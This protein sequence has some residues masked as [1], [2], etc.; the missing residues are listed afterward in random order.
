MPQ[1]APTSDAIAEQKLQ[2]AARHAD[3]TAQRPDVALRAAGGD[4]AAIEEA[5][6]LSADLVVQ[7]EGLD[8]AEREAQGWV[9]ATRSE[10]E[11]RDHQERLAEAERVHGVL[12]AEVAAADAVIGDRLLDALGRVMTMARAAD[13]ARISAGQ[14]PIIAPVIRKRLVE[15]VCG[16]LWQTCHFRPP[17]S[18]APLGEADVPR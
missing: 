15:R 6:R 13:A 1:A 5:R 16:I 3:L 17:G 2:L 12:L 11:A 18:P 7:I 10:A 4:P 9:D 14:Q 8:L